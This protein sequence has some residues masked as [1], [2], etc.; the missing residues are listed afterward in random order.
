MLARILRRVRRTGSR[1][2]TV[3]PTAEPESSGTEPVDAPRARVLAELARLCP[4]YSSGGAFRPMLR[5]H[6]P[7]GE[8]LHPVER[9]V[10]YQLR[11]QL[12]SPYASHRPRSWSA[13]EIES[14]ITQLRRLAEL[15]HPT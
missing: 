9:G 12:V 15:D 2:T 3:K 6:T 7:V 10:L 4:S 13:D 5:V 1:A 11:D 14:V 8:L